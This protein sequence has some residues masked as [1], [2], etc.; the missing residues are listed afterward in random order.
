MTGE[1]FF[2][3]P[4]NIPPALSSNGEVIK[5]VGNNLHLITHKIIHMTKA[6]MITNYWL[7][8]LMPEGP[9]WMSRTDVVQS[10]MIQR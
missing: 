1:T 10:S 2:G 7:L 5:D 9:L 8:S 3:Y 6:R 4:T